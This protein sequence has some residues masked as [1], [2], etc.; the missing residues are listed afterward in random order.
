MRH[1]V[2]SLRIISK[3]LLTLTMLFCA[4]SSAADG[5]TTMLRFPEL[6]IKAGERVLFKAYFYNE[7]LDTVEFTF[8]DSLPL[9]FKSA[10]GRSV[11]VTAVETGISEDVALRAGE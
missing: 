3:I 2:F 5:V 9:R 7:G 1:D 8:P 10:D 6:N 11:L 4:G